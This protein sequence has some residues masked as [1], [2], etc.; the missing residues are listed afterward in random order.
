MNSIPK[1]FADFNNADEKGRLRLN[2]NGSIDSIQK[3]QVDMKQGLNVLLDD[4]DSLQAVGNLEF[5]DEENIWVARI[6]W[7]SINKK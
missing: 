6:D 7:D 5:S 3:N 1:I 4:N 2:T